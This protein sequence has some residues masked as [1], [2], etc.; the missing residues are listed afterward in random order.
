MTRTIEEVCDRAKELI[1]A[2]RARRSLAALANPQ[3]G[4]GLQAVVDR[5]PPEGETLAQY[6][7]GDSLKIGLKSTAD[8]WLY[9]VAI[10]PDGSPR[11]W[12]PLPDQE[13]RAA[14]GS[15]L[16]FPGPGQTIPLDGPIGVYQVKLLAVRRPLSVS[17]LDRGLPR[18]ET[19]RRLAP[20]EW[21]EQSVS[22]R[23]VE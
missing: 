18:P 12:C 9:I 3:P 15:K 17:D 21:S 5:R 16:L 19:F 6:R 11:L 22:L 2:V 7:R 23:L 4:F 14:G 1:R 10:D 20:E 13:H 8:C